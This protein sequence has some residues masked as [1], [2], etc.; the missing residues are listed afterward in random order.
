MN[1]LWRDKG[2]VGRGEVEGGGVCGARIS[3]HTYFTLSAQVRLV[4]EGAACPEDLAKR[5]AEAG[6]ALL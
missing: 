2:L 5:A 3:H 1:W 6:A 4:V